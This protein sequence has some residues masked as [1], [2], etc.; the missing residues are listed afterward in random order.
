MA[1]VFLWMFMK[2]PLIVKFCVNS[3][4]DRKK[5]LYIQYLA[6][7]EFGFRRI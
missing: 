5:K 4:T 6:I 1:F 2:W 7:I 3:T